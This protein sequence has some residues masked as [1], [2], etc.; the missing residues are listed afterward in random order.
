MLGLTELVVLIVL[1]A[2]IPVVVVLLVLRWQRSKFSA[3]VAAMR[4][5]MADTGEPLVRGPEPAS[6]RGA[7]ARFGKVKGSG[8]IVLTARRLVFKKATGTTIEIPREEIAAVREDKWFNGAYRSGN[9]HLI[10]RLVDDTEVAF[11]VAQNLHAGWMADVQPNA[12]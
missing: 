1:A 3:D 8:V 9:L 7:T 10:V 4:Q 11:M 12:D 6:F 5:H 2:G